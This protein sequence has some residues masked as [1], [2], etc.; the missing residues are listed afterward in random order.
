M[1]KT[2][3]APMVQNAGIAFCQITTATAAPYASKT[4]ASPENLVK[5]IDGSA[6]G[7]KVSEVV[8]NATS[9]QA[10]GVMQL[11][12]QD[13]NNDIHLL[14]GY[15]FFGT[16]PNTLIATFNLAI[17]LFDFVLRENTALWVGGT[18]V[19]NPINAFAKIGEY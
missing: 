19:T 5:L 18:V 10:N 14:Q 9:T 7:T 16:T 17:P 4:V 2:F 15:E 6:E 13:E 1:A 12:L 11:W 3:T 8:F